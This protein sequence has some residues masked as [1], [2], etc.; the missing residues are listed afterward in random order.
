MALLD[1]R[2]ATRPPAALA[3]EVA[4]R[5]HV[6]AQRNLVESRGS[7]AKGHQHCAT[8]FEIALDRRDTCTRE[9]A[10][11]RH[12]ERG[13]IR[14]R[15]LAD[16]VRARSLDREA[17]I[18]ERA[19]GGGEIRDV[20]PPLAFAPMISARGSRCSMTEKN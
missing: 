10:N 6:P 7:R 20:R 15:A 19:D 17:R 16:R 12:D 5:A 18:G 14:E 8:A 11:V 2:D 3:V 13:V 1:R 9:N 4:R